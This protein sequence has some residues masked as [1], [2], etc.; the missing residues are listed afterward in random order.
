MCTVIVEVPGDP[1][2]AVRLLA[3][4]DEDPARPWDA[5]G[6]WWPSERPGVV[7]VRDRRANGAWLAAA[8][9][10]G[11][12]AVLLNRAE[13]GGRGAPEA[14][15]PLASRGGLVLDAV[16]GA[17]MPAHPRTANFNLVSI[18]GRSVALTTWDGEQR[19]RT[20]LDPGVH[21]V[22]HHDLDDPRTERIETWLPR[23]R[24][25]AGA[26][27]AA[28]RHEWIA[29]L[30]R[31][32]ALDPADERAIIRDNR[33]HGYPTL[34]LL[35]CVAEVSAGGVALSTATL[36]TPSLWNHPEFVDSLPR[37]GG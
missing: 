19:L 12:L 34:S 16:S 3:V 15:N 5:P 31:S 32:A 9:A 29:L 37:T 10:Q 25:L 20:E 18:A 14:G 22:A 7:G 24:E 28:W 6:A 17:E 36:A 30:D 8:P 27:A 11:R 33:S 35:A 23:F 13:T 1:S 2:G 4:R 26:P 21:M